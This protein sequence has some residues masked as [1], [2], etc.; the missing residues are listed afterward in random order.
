MRIYFLSQS[1]YPH[2]GG[3]S[4]Y[5][6]NLAKFLF[7]N[8]NRVVEVHLRTSGQ[9]SAEEIKG[10]RVQRVPREP[11]EEKVYA[12]YY[13]F[14]EA[15]YKECHYNTTA[16]KRHIQDTKGFGDFVKVNNYFGRQLRELLEENP[17]DVV[18]VHDFQLLF[19]YK[20]VPR[21]TPLVLTWHIPFNVS[22][23]K[24][25]A[26]FLVHHMKQYDK[27][28]FSS[29]E[30]IKAALKHGL[31]RKKTE[32]IFPFVD[33]EQFRPLEKNF[34]ILEKLGLPKN[35]KIILCVQRVDAKSGH[36]QLILAMK[37]ILKKE[38]NAFLV[39]VGS[40]SLSNRISSEREKLKKHVEDL[41]LK[42]G[43]SDNV[44]FFGN[45]DYSQMPEL[46][47]ASELVTLCSKNEGF[48]LS[49]SEAMACAK[50]VV[51]TRVGGIKLQIKNNQN[52]FLV[53]PGDYLSTAEKILQILQSP[54]LAKKMSEKS[55][56]ESGK[57]W[58]DSAMEKHLSIYNQLMIQKNELLR[59]ERL[60]KSKIKAI[61][62]DFDRT[63]TDSPPSNGFDEKEI[64]QELLEKLGN[65]GIDL[66]L[67]TGRPLEY[68]KA[69]CKKFNAFRCVIAENGCVVFFPKTKRLIVTN[70]LYMDKARE[71]IKKLGF[72]GTVL[73]L[74]GASVKIK[75]V[76]KV[77]KELGGLLFEDKVK[78]VRNVDDINFI[79]VRVDKGYG[80]RTAAQ[81]LNINLENT[82]VI[83]DG[84]NDVGMF[85]NPG[86]KI[87]L[88]NAH[89]RLK[90]LAHEVTK[91][92]S[93]RGMR[94]IIEKMEKKP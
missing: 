47:N 67:A 30:Y 83:G 65:L 21:G 13:S 1:F 24:H 73:G 77:E 75:Y 91:N 17:A 52:G 57:F 31:P 78:W 85:L 81:Y 76:K 48:G 20:F 69:F 3:V 27:V 12:G 42:N 5:L 68:V 40:K 71:K 46:Y 63:L 35:A 26:G 9:T 4:T 94:E 60:E 74:V 82:I 56:L 53:K 51:G 59:L 88:A 86:Y 29:P 33:P 36:E 38:P 92:K 58:I 11:I 34:Q 84:E 16:F 15:V 41:V 8:G 22:M 32:L 72:P 2:I 10:I 61:I 90:K 55:L 64:D 89:P 43:L 25:L 54:F 66:F 14:K 62:T 23:S 18:H 93:T 37:E 49:I 80:I 6:L 70:S 87:A 44:L 28:I 7:T 50:P 79:P 19:A 45:A 39:F